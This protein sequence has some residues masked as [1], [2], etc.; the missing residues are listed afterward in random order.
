M[1]IRS[2]SLLVLFL[3]MSACT[4]QQTPTIPA[5]VEPQKR[6]ATAVQTATV[7]QIPSPTA[8]AGAT[9]QLL[10]EATDTPITE[11]EQPTT[12]PE[13]EQIMLPEGYVVYNSAAIMLFYPQEWEVYRGPFPG[14]FAI[15]SFSPF[16]GGFS[17][18]ED[19]AIVIIMEE[20]SGMGRPLAALVEFYLPG[21]GSGEVL[22]PAQATTINGQDAAVTTV[23]CEGEL[24]SCRIGV[25]AG[26]DRGLLMLG[27]AHKTM[28]ETFGPQFD[29]MFKSVIIKPEPLPADLVA[30]NESAKQYL[31]YSDTELGISLKYPEGWTIETNDGG[32]IAIPPPSPETDSY[33]TISPA[34]RVELFIDPEDSLEEIVTQYRINSLEIS[35]GDVLPLSDMFTATFNGLDVAWQLFATTGATAIG[36]EAVP[37]TI[38]VAAFDDGGNRAVATGV[39]AEEEYQVPIDMM[40]S[41]I[42]VA[43]RI[44]QPPGDADLL[45]LDTAYEG[46]WLENEPT[47]LA[48][49]MTA[50]VPVIVVLDVLDGIAEI[51]ISNPEG[52]PVSGASDHYVIDI[53]ASVL[54]IQPELDGRYHARISDAM[55]GGGRFELYLIDLGV[56]TP[57]AVDR[58][59]MSLPAGGANEHV[60]DGVAGQP[61]II[62]GTSA[63]DLRLVLRDSSGNYLEE[64]RGVG[65]DPATLFFVPESDGAYTAE[66]TELNGQRI[67]YEL[68][69]VRD[70]RTE[71]GE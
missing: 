35:F 8:I 34:D 71:V 24:L 38:I 11:Q 64:N 7:T 22:E 68:L 52:H 9:T 45:A 28:F 63:G 59:E 15:G 39:I 54:L 20:V 25:F 31:A 46:L 13:R 43:E 3:L 47:F 56:E 30:L 48:F 17:Q 40:I 26:V 50:D 4:I 32:L 12:T 55:F 53:S 1:N 61:M 42:N 36:V 18:G 16:Y 21:F 6:E 70:V 23:S 14:S 49:D 57:L 19:S 66:V 69:I 2:F 10:P 51:E 37:M 65:I 5:T 27:I 33:L 29:E 60:I 67:D 58:M 44:Y 41:S 62:Y